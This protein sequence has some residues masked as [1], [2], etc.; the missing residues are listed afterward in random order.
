MSSLPQFNIGRNIL[1]GINTSSD[2]NGVFVV[3]TN[4]VPSSKI[5]ANQDNDYNSGNGGIKSDIYLEYISD[6]AASDY[7][8]KISASDG[9]LSSV[10]KNINDAIKDIEGGD[11]AG[12]FK[13]LEVTDDENPSNMLLKI[14][15]TSGDT[16]FTLTN[17]T[18]DGDFN[19]TC[20]SSKISATVDLTI[21]TV[22]VVNDATTLKDNL[23]VSGTLT[24]DRS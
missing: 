7:F 8:N 10:L 6:A 12:K 15:E 18:Y 21:D 9:Y 23:S 3:G 4:E 2:N 16:D 17:G 24:V 22:L 14:D 13:G 19:V 11:T 1:A 5:G 20:N